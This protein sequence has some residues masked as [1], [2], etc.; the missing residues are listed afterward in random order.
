[1]GPFTE[2]I[3]LLENNFNFIKLAMEELPW[4][5]GG[6]RVYFITLYPSF[7]AVMM[8]IIK[9]QQLFLLFN[10]LL[11]IGLSSGIITIFFKILRRYI[12]NRISFLFTILILLHPMYLS[13]TY[14]ISM[15]IPILFFS[16]IAIY[17]FLKERFILAGVF[18]I[19]S[20]SIKAPSIAISMSLV[21]L[22]ILFYFKRRER[23][24]IKILCFY[25]LPIWI[26]LIYEY[27]GSN[28]FFGQEMT[29]K[30][31]PFRGLY[32][33]LL[34]A[35][36]WPDLF[37]FMLLVPICF[38]I[39]FKKYMKTHKTFLNL[40]NHLKKDEIEVISVVICGSLLILLANYKVVIPKYLLL[41]FPFI[42]ILLYRVVLRNTKKY[43]FYFVYS[44][45]LMFFLLNLW[46]DVYYFYRD[47]LSKVFKLPQL[48]TIS[49]YKF[50]NVGGNLESTLAYEKDMEINIETAKFVEKNYSNKKIISNWPISHMLWH[51][52][53]GYV[54]N[55]DLYVIDI[56]KSSLFADEIFEN[57]KITNNDD[58]IWI[59]SK[60]IFSINTPEVYIPGKDILLKKI[61]KGTHQIIIFQRKP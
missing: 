9:N 7:L 24:H 29:Q 15:E 27:L 61:E 17:Y 28:F 45:I 5:M 20:F 4:H 26:Y 1:M 25:S 47:M 10:H 42:F 22:Y 43:I 37:C 23:N 19:I 16:I 59:Y 12:S 3:W 58:Y 6:P 60:N 57:E 35:V 52:N 2:G 53:Y 39:L 56:Q 34:Y 44:M 36:K 54:K 49:S 41:G 8:K 40:R 11:T 48:E 38:F 18:S 14:A 51:P 50:F 13:H 32:R 31:T 21:F 33:I 46:G 55:N 30:I